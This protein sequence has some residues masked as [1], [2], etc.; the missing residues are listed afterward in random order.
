VTT[1][2]A[3]PDRGVGS[4][5]ATITFW[6]LVSRILGFVRVIAT[7]GALGIAALG[8]TYQRTNQVS[9][10]LF[11][12]LAGGMLFAVLVPTFVDHLRRTDRADVGRLAGAVATR[13]VVALGLVAAVGLALAEPLMAVLTAG[14]QGPGRQAQI[15]LG[16]FLLWFVL[17][18]LLFYGVGA[19]AS[20]VLQADHRFV[21]TSVAPAGASLVVTVTMVAFAAGHDPAQGLALTEGQKVLLGGGTLLAT[22]VLALVPMLAAARAGYPLRPGWRVPSE[23]LADLVRRGAWATGHVGLNQVLVIATVVLAGRIEGGVIAYQTAFTF[24]L[25]P[26]ALLAHPIFTSLYPR[27]ASAGA[28]NAPGADLDGFA[29]TLGQGLRTMAALVLPASAL[30]AATAAP[31]LSLVQLGEFDD[32]GVALVGSTLAA[33]LTGLAAYSATF[34]LTRASYALGDARSPTTVNLWVTGAAVGVMAVATALA[35]GRGLLV[36]FG[37]ITAATGTAGAVAL[38]RR[39]VARAGRAV[40][41]VTSLSRSCLVAAAGGGA[42]WLVVGAI[43]WASVPAAAAALGVGTVSGLV[44]G[45]AVMSLTGTADVAPILALARRARSRLR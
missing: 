4:A 18:Q 28:A 29:V 31:A 20:A 39:V 36:A 35:E 3:R 21:A 11:E 24:F 7:A 45:G 43:G 44:V 41:V 1:T 37:L 8:D 14:V 19:V 15:D 12:L 23:E 40:P 16:V 22:V 10:L 17:P 2:R 32:A 25:L 5:A 42:A 34:L 38:Y 30:L 13:A 27:L 26:H 6:N 33:Y 9:N